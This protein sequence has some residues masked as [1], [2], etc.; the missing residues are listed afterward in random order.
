LVTGAE[1]GIGWE[2]TIQLIKNKQKLR[3]W[4]LTQPHS[5]KPVNQQECASLKCENF[6][7]Y[8]E[9]ILKVLIALLLL[10]FNIYSKNDSQNLKKY[11]LIT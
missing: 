8:K 6:L 10:M 9:K 11:T 5:C 1:S 2:L 3:E 4:T 7:I